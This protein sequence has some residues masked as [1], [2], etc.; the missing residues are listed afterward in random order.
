MIKNQANE[1]MNYSKFMQNTNQ[2]LMSAVDEQVNWTIFFWIFSAGQI[3][4]I[5]I[6][7]EI[8]YHI[9]DTRIDKHI[10]WKYR[11]NGRFSAERI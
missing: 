4:N 5:R 6:F 3:Y 2:S 11:R 10:Q 1:A 9:I 7:I 8:S